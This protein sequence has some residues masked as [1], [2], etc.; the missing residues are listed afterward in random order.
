MSTVSLYPVVVSSP[1]ASVPESRFQPSFQIQKVQRGLN[2]LLLSV[3]LS[4]LNSLSSQGGTACAAGC[5][6]RGKPSRSIVRRGRS[7]VLIIALHL[8]YCPVVV[9]TF[10][11]L[12][13]IIKILKHEKD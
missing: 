5:V 3:P 2:R 10:I 6:A 11:S 7:L 4:H 12:H 8:Q 9:W 1:C 13:S